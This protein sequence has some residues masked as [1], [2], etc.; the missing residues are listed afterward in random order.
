MNAMR[1]KVT[2][3]TIRE[4]DRDLLLLDTGTQRIHQ[5]NATASFIW[6]CCGEV[7]SAEEIARLLTAEYAVEDQVALRDVAETLG[8]LRELQLV[9]DC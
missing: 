6:R 8:R 1:K 4:V 5:L 3:V 7:D 9:V 2:G